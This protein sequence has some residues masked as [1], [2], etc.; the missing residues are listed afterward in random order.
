MLT[1]LDESAGDSNH[2]GI[3]LIGT[4]PDGKDIYLMAEKQGKGE[5]STKINEVKVIF[6]LN[7]RK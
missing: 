4:K 5:L 7:T 2:W 3:I 6:L 1:R